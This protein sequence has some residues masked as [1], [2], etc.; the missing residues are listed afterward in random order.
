MVMKL[1]PLTRSSQQLP[2]ALNMLRSFLV[3]LRLLPIV[4]SA[5]LTGCQS[6]PASV[7]GTVTYDGKPLSGGFVILYCAD[8]QIVRGIIGPD[9]RYSIPNVPRGAC[10]VTV[11]TRL[12]SPLGF[13]LKKNIPPAEDGPTVPN[14]SSI[15]T[16]VTQI[17]E[18]YAIPEESGLSVKVSKADTVYDIVL[19]P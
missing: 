1:F 8:E 9:G 17:P 19:V 4:V 11:K 16:A 13:S 5:A 10:Q 7:S 2:E 3:S 15:R 18:R 12:P 14:V 6:E